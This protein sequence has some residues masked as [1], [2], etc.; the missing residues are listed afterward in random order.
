MTEETDIFF[1][2]FNVQILQ[3]KKYG[4]KTGVEADFSTTT[5]KIYDL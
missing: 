4:L 1:K 5:K 2:N 3:T